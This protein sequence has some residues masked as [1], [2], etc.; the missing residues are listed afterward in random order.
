MEIILMAGMQVMVGAKVENGE[1]NSLGQLGGNHL[2]R[3]APRR[4]PVNDH[5]WVLSDDLVELG[6]SIADR[7]LLS[8]N[9]IP[10]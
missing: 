4:K 3:T 9:C 6:G 7:E 8:V 1:R 10:L 2:A 5:D